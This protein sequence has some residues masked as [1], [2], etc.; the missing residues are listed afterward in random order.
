MMQLMLFFQLLD[1]DGDLRPDK[2]R[3]AWKLFKGKSTTN[4]DQVDADT[5]NKGGPQ[6]Q[7]SVPL[8]ES[9]FLPDF[10]VRGDIEQQGFEVGRRDN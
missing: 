7:L 4:I 9:L 2:V 1:V 10:P 5:P 6:A 8:V 3:A